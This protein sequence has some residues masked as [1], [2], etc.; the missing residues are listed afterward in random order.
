M[1][2]IKENHFFQR[3]KVAN[4]TMARKSSISLEYEPSS[5]DF[6][7]D[8]LIVS[9][10]KPSRIVDIFEKNGS[11]SYRMDI[12]ESLNQFNLE[13]VTMHKAI[14]PKMRWSDRKI[15]EFEIA[16]KSTLLRKVLMIGTCK[17]NE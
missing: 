2:E 12:Q 11:L 14:F 7:A 8:Q 4:F 10:V 17:S 16:N 6:Y 1:E 5:I 3:P 13:I 15:E 9:Y